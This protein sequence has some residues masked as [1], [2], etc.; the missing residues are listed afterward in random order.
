MQAEL[1]DGQNSL[2]ESDEFKSEKFLQPTKREDIKGLDE[3]LTPM[4]EFYLS[5]LEKTVKH[6]FIRQ[7]TQKESDLKKEISQFKKH[8]LKRAQTIEGEQVSQ[9]Y[10]A[11]LKTQLAKQKQ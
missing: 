10:L 6:D 4:E 5:E 8:K 11:N 2:T 3:D 1:E 9:S 7:I